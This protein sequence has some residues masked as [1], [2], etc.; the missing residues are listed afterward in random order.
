MAQPVARDRATRLAK[1]DTEAALDAARR[2]SEPWY[3]CQAGGS[4]PIRDARLSC[5]TRCRGSRAHSRGRPESV[6]HGRCGGMAG[7]SA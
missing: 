4:G 1:V 3:K 2:I 7:T 6:S 5:A